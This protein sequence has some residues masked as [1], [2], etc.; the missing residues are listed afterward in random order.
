M[1]GSTGFTRWRSKPAA[2]A[3]L[4]ILFA[5]RSRSARRGARRRGA[6][7]DGR[8]APPRSRP[9]PGRPMSTSITSRR[10]GARPARGRRAR[11]RQTTT[12]VTEQLE[13]HAPGSRRRRVVLHH[14]HPGAEPGCAR[15][16]ARPAPPRAAAAPSGGAARTPL[17]RP[18]PAL[19]RLDPAAVELDQPLHDREADAEAALASGRACARACAKRS[20]TRGSI[21][22][23]MPM[24]SVANRAPPPRSL[25]ARGR[26]RCVRRGRV[27]GR[28]V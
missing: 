16:E 17:P 6:A 2:R 28:V 3:R 4:P 23:A 15:A 8:G 18:G 26:P 27:L 14:Q 5:F 25:R 12:S 1:A 11:R 13:Q 19:R 20:K 9:C 10:L 22:G 7:R 21:S 24:P